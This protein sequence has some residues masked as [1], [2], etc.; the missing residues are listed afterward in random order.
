VG[1]IWLFPAIGVVE[2][3][4]GQRG[5]GGDSDAGAERDKARVV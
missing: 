1:R 4:G 2:R 3:G 5:R